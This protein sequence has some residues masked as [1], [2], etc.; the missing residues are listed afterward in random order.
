MRG[1][2]SQFAPQFFLHLPYPLNRF[3]L[4]AEAYRDRVAAFIGVVFSIGLAVILV[5]SDVALRW[6]RRRL[7]WLSTCDCPQFRFVAL[8][9]GAFVL[10]ALRD[11]DALANAQVW[12]EDGLVFLGE[13]LRL[14]FWHTLFRQYAGYLH[15][16]PRLIA[17]LSDFF[18]CASC[19][20]HSVLQ[21]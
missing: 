10:L 18:L 8:T 15:V 5:T 12:A 19:P 1:S 14:G 3:R 2:K 16:I 9:V 11:P 4:H 7:Q 13:N 17:G 20:F 21:P 6:I